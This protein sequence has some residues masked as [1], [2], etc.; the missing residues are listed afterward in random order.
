[1][2]VRGGIWA[3]LLFWGHGNGAC[4]RTVTLPRVHGQKGRSHRGTKR[5]PEMSTAFIHTMYYGVTAHSGYFFERWQ[6]YQSSMRIFVPHVLIRTEPLA[7]CLFC[8]V[9][10]PR[11]SYLPYT[12]PHFATMDPRH[13]IGHFCAEKLHFH[14]LLS[15]FH[16]YTY[17]SSHYFEAIHFSLLL[18]RHSLD[19]KHLEYTSNGAVLNL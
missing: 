9:T 1:M 8:T 2:Q 3:L 11:P 18:Q 10:V 14:T 7:N 17:C 12:Y 5:H 4:N 13:S 16:L 19:L 15:P 6:R